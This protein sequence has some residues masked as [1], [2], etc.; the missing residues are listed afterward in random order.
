ML[1]SHRNG[2]L[3]SVA[4]PSPKPA[5][6]SLPDRVKRFYERVT[7]EGS[8]SLS[9]LPKLY[10][11]DVHFINPVV[12]EVGLDKFEK[13]WVRAFDQYKVFQFADLEV[14]GDDTYFTLTYSM[15]IKFSFGPTFKTQ[16]ATDCHAR[17][18]KVYLCR[19]YFDVVGSLVQP[20][21]PLAWIYKKVFGLLVA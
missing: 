19:D 20:F 4:M 12:D 3:S 6:G 11:D 15:N 17:D 7:D 1:A 16:M 5:A 2:A 8:A 10:S 9:E 18:G 13:Q 14:V 21:P